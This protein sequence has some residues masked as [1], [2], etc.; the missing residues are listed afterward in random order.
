MFYTKGKNQQVNVS[1]G[2]CKRMDIDPKAY[3]MQTRK[4]MVKIA[5]LLIHHD[6]TLNKDNLED[7]GW[8]K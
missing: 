3:G 6:I 5:V 2:S 1:H 7:F 8:L 4:L